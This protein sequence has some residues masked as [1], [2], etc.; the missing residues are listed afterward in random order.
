LTIDDVRCTMCDVRCTNY[1]L[2][3]EI[4]QPYKTGTMKF[5]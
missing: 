5:E 3:I 2:R 4:L 1:D